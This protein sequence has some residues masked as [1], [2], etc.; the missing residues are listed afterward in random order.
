[1]IST[2]TASGFGEPL[3]STAGPSP[4]NSVNPVPAKSDP[5]M[6]FVGSVNVDVVIVPSTVTMLSMLSI[7]LEIESANRFP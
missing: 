2:P 3:A 7:R 1:M 6:L 4:K 5:A